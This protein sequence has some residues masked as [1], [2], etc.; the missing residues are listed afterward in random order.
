MAASWKQNDHTFLLKKDI[1][2]V[3]RCWIKVL[4]ANS[5]QK[6]PLRIKADCPSEESVA[7]KELMQKLDY[8]L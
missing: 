7:N 4:L 5:D 2:R 3:R 8:I 1:K 6:L